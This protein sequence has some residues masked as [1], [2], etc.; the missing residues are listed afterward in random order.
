MVVF[1]VFSATI[2]FC[3]CAC[4]CM[5]VCGKQSGCNRTAMFTKQSLVQ[6]RICTTQKSVQLSYKEK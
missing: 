5:Y 4:V 6:L 3:V 1:P 2:V